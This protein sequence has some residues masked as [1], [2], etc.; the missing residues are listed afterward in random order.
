MAISFTP[1]TFSN[2]M[3][4]GYALDENFQGVKDA[5]EDALSRTSSTDNEMNVDLD[6]NSKRILN[7]P[8]PLSSSEP[9]RLQDVQDA[10]A[11]NSAAL[12]SFS[13]AG[14][15]S[16]DNVQAAI[17]ELETDLTAVVGTTEA[18]LETKINNRV[19]EISD[20][21][22]LKA[23][24]T[25]TLSDGDQF[26]VRSYYAS[27]LYATT[28]PALY[29]YGGGSFF[30]STTSTATADDGLVFDADDAGGKFLRI[31]SG[32]VNVH[33]YGAKGDGSTDDLTALRAAHASGYNVFYPSG[34][35]L[36]SGSIQVIQGQKAYGVKGLRFPDNDMRT[37]IRSTVAS[38]PIFVQDQSTDPGQEDGFSAYDLYL[39]SDEGIQ[40]N[41]PTIT[42]T[43]GAG[44]GSP[45]LMRSEFRRL[46]LQPLTT[47]SGTGIILSKCFDFII[48][49]CEFTNFDRHLVLQGCD[50]GRV[51]TNRFTGIYG[52]GILELSTDT[53][54]S[55][56]LIINNDMV[57]VPD[58]GGRFIKTTS[59]H[60]RIKD[61]YME[62]QSGN[63]VG[64]IDMNDVSPPQYGSNSISSTRYSSILVE[65][66][67][68]DGQQ[69]AT[70]FIYRIPSTQ[71]L[72]TRIIDSGT[73]GVESSMPWLVDSGGN[74]PLLSLLWNTTNISRYELSGGRGTGAEDS[75]LKDFRTSASL[76]DT[77][78][79]RITGANI[80]HMDRGELL[81]NSAYQHVKIGD[82]GFYL[83][84]SLGTTLFHVIL[85]EKTGVNNPYLR[86]GITYNVKVVARTDGGSETLRILKIENAAGVGSA[87]DTVVD[88]Q[89]KEITFTQTGAASSTKIG[90]SFAQ[91]GG[92][93]SNNIIIESVTWTA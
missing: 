30:F 54:G 2:S 77:D 13:P 27:A 85:P 28:D 9:A 59:R 50:I 23:L 11:D 76:T 69:Y 34:E 44:A 88:A 16:S 43:D 45:Y 66:N 92:T 79:V 22:T 91:Q 37:I 75:A 55:Q 53:F 64:F 74:A 56:N 36:V 14:N 61:N 89:N 35:Y 93:P 3:P 20:V 5:L 87:I 71:L 52:Y 86:N 84:P 19:R 62:Q 31:F 25:S 15:I 18:N 48:E 33:W 8:V 68:L 72:N 38:T 57:G 29:G 24:D 46:S 21:A 41:D 58:T 90:L 7:L 80:V 60:V 67:R 17:E 40:L 26:E 6:M 81:R 39:I 65:G 63:F 73:T 78:H 70:A 32:D 10:L 47:G 1:L 82:G 12:I 51:S 49:Q 4:S 83:Q 42:I